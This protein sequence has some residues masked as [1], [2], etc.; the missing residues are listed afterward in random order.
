VNFLVAHPTIE[1]LQWY[2]IHQDL[3]VP[4]G[5]LPRLKRILTTHRMATVI[6]RD[7]SLIQ[8]R[9]MECISQISL[10]FNTM[11]LLQAI[12]GSRLQ[13]LYIWRIDELAQ[14]RRVAALF[15]NI[16]TL[17]IPNLGNPFGR[18]DEDYSIY[19]VSLFLDNLYRAST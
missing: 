16:H 4:N 12:D 2:P 3:L 8:Q 1:D 7:R 5:F 9:K 13:E 19:F 14:L 11:Q 17:G 15:P 6:L 10:G 18:R